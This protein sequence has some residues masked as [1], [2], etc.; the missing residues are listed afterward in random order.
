MGHEGPLL[1]GKVRPPSPKIPHWVC[2]GCRAP[3]ET[4]PIRPSAWRPRVFASILPCPPSRP[5]ST[6]PDIPRLTKTRL[7]VA[8]PGSICKQRTQLPRLMRPGFGR[9]REH[10][11]RAARQRVC[12]TSAISLHRNGCPDASLGFL[13]DRNLAKDSVG[14]ARCRPPTERGQDKSRKVRHGR[15]AEENRQIRRLAQ[16]GRKH[17]SVPIHATR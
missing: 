9:S 14:L 5:L 4:L 7:L 16:G 17:G 8:L 13:S 12:I 2:L 11:A 15:A 3:A 1:L 10:D 6:T